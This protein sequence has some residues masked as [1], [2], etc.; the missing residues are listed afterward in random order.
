[1]IVK[2]DVEGFECEVLDSG[3]QLFLHVR[4]DYI[5]VEGKS[6]RVRR[7][8]EQ[9]AERH[10]YMIGAFTGSGDEN[11]LLYLPD[12]RWTR[13]QQNA[14]FTTAM[15]KT[16]GTDSVTDSLN[17]IARYDDKTNHYTNATIRVRSV[18]R[19]SAPRVASAAQTAPPDFGWHG[20]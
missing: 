7:C 11:I 6:P 16:G 17:L 8:I 14:S 19:P 18:Y 4:P 12:G 15:A 20:K 2:M 13:R 10:G 5:L 9:Q 3:Q 1:M